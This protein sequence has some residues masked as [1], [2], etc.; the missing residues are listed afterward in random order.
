LLS[1]SLIA[2]STLQHSI[3]YFKNANIE[4]EDE[5]EHEDEY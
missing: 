2:F 5:E 3:T 4:D 1:S